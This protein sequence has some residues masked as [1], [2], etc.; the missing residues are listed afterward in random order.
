MIEVARHWNEC[1][2]IAEEE[3][4]QAGQEIERL[5]IEL[6]RRNAELLTSRAMFKDGE[7]KTHDLEVR[8]ENAEGQL[9]QAQIENQGLTDQVATLQDQ[10]TKANE[11]VASFADKLRLYKSKLNE[12]IE[13]QQRLFNISGKSYKDTLDEMRK[14]SEERK[15]EIDAVSKALD[16]SKA[17]QQAMKTQLQDIRRAMELE[18]EGSKC[19]NSKNNAKKIF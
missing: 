9:K 10:T 18:S 14:W 11:R 2:K 17:R 5:Q 15:S 3:K 13:E 8:F 1:M 19:N 16:E 12:A 4:L 7:A 6:R